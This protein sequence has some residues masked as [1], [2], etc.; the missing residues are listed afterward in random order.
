MPNIQN[1][2]DLLFWEDPTTLKRILN[3]DFALIEGGSTSIVNKVQFNNFLFSGGDVLQMRLFVRRLDGYYKKRAL[4]SDVSAR[5]IGQ[6][7]QDDKFMEVRQGT[8]PFIPIGGDFGNDGSGTNYIELLDVLLNTVSPVVEC[9]VVYPTGK[10]TT[11]DALWALG[12]SYLKDRSFYP[13]SS[14]AVVIVEFNK[15]VSAGDESEKSLGI[16]SNDF[17]M[18]DAVGSTSPTFV[19]Q[20]QSTSAH[21]SYDGVDDKGI[22]IGTTAIYSAKSFTVGAWIKT[23]SAG[24]GTRYV[25]SMNGASGDK[26]AIIVQ[27]GVAEFRA[28][29]DTETS[30]TSVDDD[31]WHLM[32]GRRISGSEM[33]VFVDA[34]KVSS[35]A[36][37]STATISPTSAAIVG[38]QSFVGGG[39]Y[40][41]EIDTI[42]YWKIALNDNQIAKLYR[43]TKLKHGF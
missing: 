21:Y 40:A 25:F 22:D 13:R 10:L 24:A 29:A 18:F 15:G 33:A 34:V 42:F 26:W 23:P 37:A 9:R 36:I 11:G 1:L 17:D 31:V 3:F 39:N 28:N 5:A 4:E 35:S 19:P 6:E 7:I 43:S 20:T 27:G 12:V 32:I 2:S 41:G 14:E 38:E 30:A 16:G 8:G